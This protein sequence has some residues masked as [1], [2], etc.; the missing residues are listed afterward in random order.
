MDT[1]A[2]L[3][4]AVKMS[5]YARKSFI[6]AISIECGIIEEGPGFTVAKDRQYTHIVSI[7]LN[8]D[9]T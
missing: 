3:L 7:N 5:R 9:I 8:I 1:S 2:T 4:K 6:E